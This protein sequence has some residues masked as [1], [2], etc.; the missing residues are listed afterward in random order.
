M[1]VIGV[2]LAQ[3]NLHYGKV[4]WF[5]TCV[6]WSLNCERLNSPVSL[7]RTKVSSSKCCE[8]VM[9]GRTALAC[10][11]PLLH[12][13]FCASLPSLWYLSTHLTRCITP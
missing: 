5:D 1:N 6:C 11:V 9:L 2:G 4:F 8:P 12:F 3:F 10:S 7:V 13:R